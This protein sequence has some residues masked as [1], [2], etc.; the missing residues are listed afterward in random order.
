MSLV[1]VMVWLW[2]VTTEDV[3]VGLIS[4]SRMV[5]S[6]ILVFPSLAIITT[7]SLLNSDLISTS[8][9]MTISIWVLYCLR[10]VCRGISPLNV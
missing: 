8:K 1:V 10:N 9:I 7:L 5:I 2:V 6:T 3:E 4:F